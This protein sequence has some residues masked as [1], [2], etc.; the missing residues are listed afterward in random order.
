MHQYTIIGYVQNGYYLVMKYSIRILRKMQGWLLSS[1]KAVWLLIIHFFG[2]CPLTF[3]LTKDEDRSTEYTGVP[4]PWYTCYFMMPT[5][6]GKRFAGLNIRGISPIK[7]FTWIFSRCLGQ[8]CW[9]FNY[10]YIIA[11]CSRE[12]FRGILKNRESL[13]QWIFPRLR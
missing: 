1:Q 9:L 4:P 8:G 6:N 3:I 2:G 5:I 10:T 13:A 7:F 12:N 11:K